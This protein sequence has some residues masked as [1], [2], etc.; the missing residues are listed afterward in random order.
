VKWTEEIDFFFIGLT[1]G[2][3]CDF[4]LLLY[5]LIGGVST[6]CLKG[7]YV[8]EALELV[9]C[10]MG[11]AVGLAI[12]GEYMDISSKRLLRDYDKDLMLRMAL[13]YSCISG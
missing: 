9:W 4:G 12:E 1:Y 7:V 10:L 11:L 5:C 13:R 6:N 2:L 3:F 8:K